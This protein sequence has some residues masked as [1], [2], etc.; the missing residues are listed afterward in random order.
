MHVGDPDLLVEWDKIEQVVSNSMYCC[1]D[2]LVHISLATQR[3]YVYGA[4]Y[5][6]VS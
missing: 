3:E 1:D 5:M 2:A 6:C 4:V